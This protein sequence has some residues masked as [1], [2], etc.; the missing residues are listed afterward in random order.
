MPRVCAAGIQKAL[1]GWA[2]MTYMELIIQAPLEMIL[3]PR[4]PGR[5]LFTGFGDIQ[6]VPLPA[7]GF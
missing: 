6:T 5:L 1:I 2:G 3:S 4:K 7:D